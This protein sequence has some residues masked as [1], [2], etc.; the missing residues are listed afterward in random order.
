M[1]EFDFYNRLY[2]GSTTLTNLFSSLSAPCIGMC[3]TNDITDK[4]SGKTGTIMIVKSRTGY[5]GAVCFCS[6][7]TIE[8]NNY[9]S[10]TQTV[11]GWKEVISDDSTIDASKVVNTFTGKTYRWYIKNGKD[12]DDYIE[13][14]QSGASP[15]IQL[16]FVY[17]N[18]AENTNTFYDIF[19][20]NG[21][22]NIAKAAHTHDHSDIKGMASN[23]VMTSNGSGVLTES[24]VTTTELGYLDGVTSSIQTQLNNKAASNHSHALSS[25]TGTLDASKITGTSIGVSNRWKL[26][27][28]ASSS[29]DYVELRNS[30]A[31]PNVGLSLVFHDTSANSNTFYNLIN[32]K[33]ELLFADKEYVDEQFST[34]LGIGGHWN[35]QEKYYKSINIKM[36]GDAQNYGNFCLLLSIGCVFLINVPQA[37]SSFKNC[38]YNKIL[39]ATESSYNITPSSC[40]VIKDGSQIRL[41]M[42]FSPNIN[43][44]VNVLPL[45][46]GLKITD[47]YSATT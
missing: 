17:H 30:G 22:F 42:V 32:E 2:T 5:C 3:T 6:D 21:N 16:S 41:K 34:L 45:V 20:E 39:N 29:A 33:G 47:I 35:S 10:D 44:S 43:H 19:D 18:T 26:G 40:Q 8:V 12:N 1:E 31:S 7:G 25:M 27:N 11:T 23:R 14:R 13:L 28:T 9:N 4:P 24:S 36:Y 38:T 15:T 37:E 46:G